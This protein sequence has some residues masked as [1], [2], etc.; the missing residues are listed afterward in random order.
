[1]IPPPSVL[2]VMFFGAGLATGL[3]H[4]WAVACGALVAGIVA[5][6]WQRRG[7]VFM[8]GAAA[9]FMIGL[10][11]RHGVDGTCAARLPGQRRAGS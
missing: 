10:M 3:A 11:A 9:G 5:V 2:L 1:M 7:M 4:F 8:A 6:R